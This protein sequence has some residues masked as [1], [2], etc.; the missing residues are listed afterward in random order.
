MA[1]GVP[2]AVNLRGLGSATSCRRR[3]LTKFQGEYLWREY[4]KPG[5]EDFDDGSAGAGAFGELFC[6][7]IVYYRIHPIAAAG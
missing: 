5:T 6:A 3:S 7:A 1:I 2:N 4:R